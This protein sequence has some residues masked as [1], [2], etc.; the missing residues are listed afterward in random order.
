M[1]LV[2]PLPPSKNDAYVEQAVAKKGPLIAAVKKLMAGEKGAWHA[3][4]RAMSV[5]R[6]RSEAYIEYEKAVQACVS[7]QDVKPLE[8]PVTVTVTVFFPDM[9]RDLQNVVDVLF[10]V[11][12]GIAYGNDRQVIAFTFRREVSDDP[13]VVVTVLGENAD[14]FA[15]RGSQSD[16]LDLEF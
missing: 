14:L 2:L 8:G 15:P 5:I 12:E 13:R 9:R 7:Y 16:S 11:L 3:V 4:K 10:D 1:K 6:H